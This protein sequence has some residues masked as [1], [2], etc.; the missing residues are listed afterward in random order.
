MKPVTI[1]SWMEGLYDLQGSKQKE[2]KISNSCKLKI[3]NYVI[4]NLKVHNYGD[5]SKYKT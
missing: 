5:K 1:L 2:Y 3:K 4:Y